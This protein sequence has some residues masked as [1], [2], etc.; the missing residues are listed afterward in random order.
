MLKQVQVDY[1][2]EIQIMPQELLRSAFIPMGHMTPGDATTE[3]HERRMV[4]FGNFRNVGAVS[5]DADH[6]AIQ[7]TESTGNIRRWYSFRRPDGS[8]EKSSRTKT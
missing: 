5:V 3:A 2:N 4:A 8:I 6:S 1:F 7:P